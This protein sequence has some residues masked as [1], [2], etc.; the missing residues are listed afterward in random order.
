MSL[1]KICANLHVATY[2]SQFY[3]LG[4]FVYVPLRRVLPPVAAF[5]GTFIVSG[6]IHDLV[7]M[8]VRRSWG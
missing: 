1:K 6:G 4:K 2:I 7:T 5:I 3:G 8:A